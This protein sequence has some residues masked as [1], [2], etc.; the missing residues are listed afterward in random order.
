MDK[1]TPG[2]AI[3]EIYKASARAIRR[4]SRPR[5]F[6]N[7]L[8]FNAEATTLEGRSLKPITSSARNVPLE[9]GTLRP[10][11]TSSRGALI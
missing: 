10:R 7:N 11:G 5:S 3:L 8:F 2:E 9:Q 4:R 6:F 1:S